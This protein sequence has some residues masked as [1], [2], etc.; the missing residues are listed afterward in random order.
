MFL[1]KDFLKLESRSLG[2]T[3][4]ITSSGAVAGDGGVKIIFL[5]KE[6][7][8][9]DPALDGGQEQVISWTIDLFTGRL[10]V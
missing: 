5:G 4:G 10:H 1:N 2:S 8:R 9:S 7:Q 6:R 3:L